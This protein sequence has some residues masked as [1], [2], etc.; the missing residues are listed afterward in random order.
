MSQ[1]QDNANSHVKKYQRKT[2]PGLT[3]LSQGEPMI[4]LSGGALALALL[5]IFGL[6]GL[7]IYQGM[8]SFWPGRLYLVTLKDG[9]V[10]MGELTAEEDYTV[11][12]NLADQN[13]NATSPPK[14]SHRWQ[15]RTDNFEFQ[16]PQN[17]TY[18][19][20]TQDER[21]ETA[22]TMP[23]WAMLFERKTL[24]RF[25][26]T[27]HKFTI[28]KTRPISSDED[29]L[30]DIHSFFANNQSSLTGPD[31]QDDEALSAWTATLDSLEQEIGSIQ[32]KLDAIQVENTRSFITQN[33]HGQKDLVGVTETGE[34]IPLAEVEDNQNLI[35]IREVIQGPQATYDAYQQHHASAQESVHTI[36]RIS[37]HEVGASS[38]SQE[39][40]RL[41]L[42][43]QEL[44]HDVFVE[45][46]AN[47]TYNLMISLKA[48]QADQQKDIRIVERATR[49][50]GKDSAMAKV[51]PD[52][53]AALNS[54]RTAEVS[55]IKARLNEIA[56]LLEQVPPAAKQA[57]YHFV[58]VRFDVDNQIAAIQERINQIEERNNRFGLFATTAQGTEAEL[59]LG[60]IVRAFPANQLDWTGRLEVYFARWGEFLFADPREANSE[61]GVF[62]AI[63][64]TVAMTMIMSLIVVPFGV[65]AALYLREYAKSGPIV[66]IIR[67]SINNL[68]GVP[69]IVFGVFGYGFLIL[70]V[71]AYIDGGPGNANLP[72]IPKLWWWLMAAGLA[73][74]A[75]TAFLTTSYSLGSRKVLTRMR[76][77]TLGIASLLLWILATIAFIALVA[78]T[79]DFHGFYQANLPNPTF[80]KGGLLWASLTLALLTLPVVIVATEEALAAVP[81]SLREGSYGCGASKWQTIRRIV[82]PHALPGIMTG[83]ILAMARGA[84][85]VAPL[86]LVG[87]L[88]LAPELPVDL[89]APFVHLDRSFM[90]LGFHIFD[91]GFQSPNSEAAKPM[92]FTTTLLLITVVATL[93]LFAI[94][95]RA[96]LRKRFHSG[97]F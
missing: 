90:H 68:A 94:W 78:F 65:L 57:V 56:Q 3:I 14:S 54:Q 13:E 37:E 75:F 44:T 53:V 5:M 18:Q 29:D 42:R 73:I 30:S 4:W 33:H 95:L 43:Q 45:G 41:Q 92:V 11:S 15:Y 16:A 23:T 69:S 89:S 35:E 84:G 83:M 79:P 52:L 59:K 32:D 28:S 62:P 38:R 6:L 31:A 71:G 76:T 24:G 9:S 25:V 93:N 64:G 91:L 34:I 19:W 47:E 22:P 74:V 39:E 27:P 26:G 1:P 81:N 82:L 40:A 97:Q 67:I 7:I 17:G 21:S 88:K 8:A 72:S 58:N 12:R 50:L 60:D 46:L 63:W 55:R 86:M 61:G 51:G 80:G 49:L 36:E 87:V 70:V 48:I 85:E 2:R 10:L 77:P 20:V 66:S 96:R